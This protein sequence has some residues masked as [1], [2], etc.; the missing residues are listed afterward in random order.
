MYLHWSLVSVALALIMIR[1]AVRVVEI[2][3]LAIAR[4]IAAAATVAAT[5]QALEATAAT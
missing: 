4:R 3:V 5:F 2:L 1:R